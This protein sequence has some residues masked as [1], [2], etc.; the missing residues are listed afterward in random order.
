MCTGGVPGV[1]WQLGLIEASYLVLISD[2]QGRPDREKGAERDWLD[3]GR[4]L[5]GCLDEGDGLQ[6]LARWPMKE[7]ISCERLAMG[8]H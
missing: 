8:A 5:G 1:A 3:R 7:L 2:D 4:S 6:R